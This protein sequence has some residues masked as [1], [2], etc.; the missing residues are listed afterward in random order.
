MVR[1]PRVGM[2]LVGRR[3]VGCPSSGSSHSGGHCP[4]IRLLPA[5]MGRRRR[6]D[7]SRRPDNWHADAKDTEEAV[8]GRGRTC[9]SPC[10]RKRRGSRRRRPPDSRACRRERARPAAVAAARATPCPRPAGCRRHRRGSPGRRGGGIGPRLGHRQLVRVA[11]PADRPSRR[12]TAQQV[13]RGV[14]HDPVQ[15]GG[16]GGITAEVVGPPEG[17]DHRL[18]ERVRRIVRVADDAQGDRPQPVLVAQ[19][20]RA[21]GLLVPGQVQPEQFG[22]GPRVGPPSGRCGRTRGGRIRMCPCHRRRPRQPLPPRR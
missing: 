16:D 1:V 7:G 4:L 10:P 17:R 21:E 22:V 2:L 20:Q 5:Q 9:S 11:R 15:P 6:A 12:P 19:E 18:L 13:K 8:P 3:G 14:D